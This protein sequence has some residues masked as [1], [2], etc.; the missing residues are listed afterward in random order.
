MSSGRDE[1]APPG[2]LE[3][4]DIWPP[5]GR[6]RR[7]GSARRH[8]ERRR[9]PLSRAEIVRAALTVA[10]AEGAGAINMRRIAREL[11]AGTMSLYWHVAD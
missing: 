10:D 6:A 1:P 3:L 5:A 7:P 9:S 8:E 11:D 2:E 4:D